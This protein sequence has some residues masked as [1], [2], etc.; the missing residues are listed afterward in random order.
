MQSPRL[1]QE[2][3]STKDGKNY[4]TGD[5]YTFVVVRQERARN[6]KNQADEIIRA[7]AH[8]TQLHK[9]HIAFSTRSS[10][11]RMGLE[12]PDENSMPIPLVVLYG[13][14]GRYVG[15]TRDPQEVQ[16]L[17]VP[18]KRNTTTRNTNNM[19][20]IGTPVWYT[21]SNGQNIATK[22]R[23]IN[24]STRPPAY[25]L[26]VRTAPH[27]VERSRL[28][29]INF[30]GLP[31]L[32]ATRSTRS[33]SQ[34]SHHSRETPPME[35]SLSNFRNRMLPP[36]VLQ[37]R[38]HTSSRSHRRNNHHLNNNKNVVSSGSNSNGGN[39]HKF[40]ESRHGQHKY[41][42]NRRFVAV[43]ITDQKGKTRKDG[44][45]RT[46]EALKTE[47]GTQLGKIVL[48]RS[49]A[50]QLP[51]SIQRRADFKLYIQ[52][53]KPFVIVAKVDVTP[54]HI[55]LVTDEKTHISSHLL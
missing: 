25:T 23:G 13:P 20:N 50:H 12:V 35:E 53:G 30:G 18:V 46:M 49:D 32:P 11:R 5:K 43:I 24:L 37:E 9:E 7:A 6:R 51:Q 45:Q 31:P 36:T 19:L 15:S 55:I 33:A 2:K 27:S 34:G 41:H 44:I 22:I 21:Q 48:S 26:E 14:G 16:H 29:P 1:R 3:M 28:T 4:L 10:L 8:A 38:S 17:L 52:E 39:L 42:P 47:L 54:A 40:V